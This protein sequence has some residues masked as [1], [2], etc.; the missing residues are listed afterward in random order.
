MRTAREGYK[1]KRPETINLQKIAE[2]AESKGM[3]VVESQRR[4]LMYCYNEGEYAVFTSSSG[5]LRL[6]PLQVETLLTEL[7]G[8]KDDVD[9]LIKQGRRN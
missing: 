1:V 7:A 8:I 9:E 5:V 2:K 4:G 3:Y 6:T